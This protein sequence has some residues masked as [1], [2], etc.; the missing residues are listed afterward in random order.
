MPASSAPS[1]TAPS[2][3]SLSE[4]DT[5]LST[6]AGYA[7][8]SPA[9]PDSVAGQPAYTVTVTPRSAGGLV[10]SAALSFDAST[11][12]PLHFAL[13]ARGSSTPVLE[14]TVTG[15]A[16]QAVPLSDVLVPPPS[17][18]KIVA[19]HAPSPGG[20]QAG[21]PAPPSGLAAVAQA[22][23]FTLVAPAF[24]H[25]GSTLALRGGA[26]RRLRRGALTALISYGQG[27]GTIVARASAALAAGLPARRPARPA[28]R[29]S[30]SPA[31]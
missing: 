15:I 23:P 31:A 27:L 18:T 8:V 2:A 30:P 19:L 11:G 4:I 28:A 13:D 6:L 22:V 14:L 17:G 5:L 20:A 10:G 26:A 16:Y 12:V 9:T 25:L 3:P 24:E 29:T 1:A 7:D 21:A